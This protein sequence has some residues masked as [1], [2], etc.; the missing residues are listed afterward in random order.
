MQQLGIKT[1]IATW[2]IRFKTNLCRSRHE[3]FARVGTLASPQEAQQIAAQKICPKTRQPWS[4]DILES[5]EG[6]QPAP[7]LPHRG[8]PTR[9]RKGRPLPLRHD[10]TNN[11][12]RS[13]FSTIPDLQ[14]PFETWSVDALREFLS[15]SKLHQQFRVERPILDVDRG[16]VSLALTKQC[17]F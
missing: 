3:H 17:Q 10:Y 9:K 13:G 4:E 11:Y 1:R 14:T 12:Q 15:V 7:P 8:E 16:E 6:F 5:L 2:D